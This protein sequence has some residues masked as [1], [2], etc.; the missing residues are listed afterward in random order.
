MI[1]IDYFEISS[2]INDPRQES[3][4]LRRKTIFNFQLLGK[5]NNSPIQ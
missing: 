5:L 4:L 3:I 1:H 2:I